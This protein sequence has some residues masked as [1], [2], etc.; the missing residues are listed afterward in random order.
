MVGGGKAEGLRLLD[1]AGERVPPFVVVPADLS[2]EQLPG[3]LAVFAED[4]RVAVR[5]SALD[6]DE[7]DQSLAGHH[8]SLLDVALSDVPEAVARVRASGGAD[9]A[10]PVVVQQM[11]SADVS[12]V[13]F[14]AEPA[15]VLD[16]AVVSAGAGA[17][18]VVAADRPS[19]T[20]TVSR[21]D[22]RRWTTAEAG[23]PD[24]P[25]GLVDDLVA[26]AARVESQRGRP[27][28][29]EWAWS[30][31]EGLWVLQAR[32]ITGL[33]DDDPVTLDN[34]N[35]VENYPGTCL[36][37]T[38]SFVPIS[39]RE[40]FTS[41]ARRLSGDEAVVEAFQPVLSRL[42]Q[43]Q[44]GRLFYR[45]ESWYAV[46][47]LVPFSKQYTRAW[48]ASLGVAQGGSSG[49]LVEVS[50]RTRLRVAWSLLQEL[51]T[52]PE[53]VRALAPKVQRVQDW[54]APRIES[55]TSLDELA[56][57]YQQI[58]TDL[59]AHWD[60]TLLND[61]RAF[62]LP[63]LLGA[64]L[65]PRRRRE[66]LWELFS[67][68][69]SIESLR[70]VAAM[71][72]L[73]EQAPQ[74]APELADVTTAEQAREWLAGP[75]PFAAEVREHVQRYG[76]RWLAEL[77]LESPTLRTD[78]LLV[79]QSLRTPLSLPARSHHEARLLRGPVRP[80]LARAGLE[81][82]ALRESSR[83]DRARVH[84]LVRRIALRAGELMVRDGLLDEPSQ[85]F[86]L[87]MDEVFAPRAG[88][89][90]V[91]T[92]RQDDHASFAQLPPIGRLTFAGEPFDLHPPVVGTVSGGDAAG[93]ERTGLLR[94]QGVSP[95]TAAGPVVVVE[96][97][98][99]A[100][101]LAG[102]VVVCAT[103]DPGW[104]F[105]LARCAALVA[106]QGSPLSH[107][108]IVA[109]E[110]GVPVVVGLAG[111]TNSF[112]SGERVEVDGRRGTVRRLDVD[113]GTR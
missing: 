56:E 105:L 98:S 72:H 111:A 50:R 112:T 78:P 108:A 36:P 47:S 44:S 79:V 107:T 31:S 93:G 68:V 81:A 2:L 100:G 33:P 99:R 54:A 106:E 35:I 13:V 49:P 70:P 87:T 34:A 88:L 83:L 92:S 32:P 82:I 38:L 66:R 19:C 10:I 84:G 18:S 46:M 73:A 5:S 58:L 28:D 110:L 48:R 97:A 91:I 69:A 15:G 96:D 86:W 45:L 30:S 21:V 37:L 20:V 59:V 89:R 63:A 22:G 29:V 103:T 6:E 23:A 53:Q 77:K 52:T 57:T 7:D 11:V 113:E 75:N 14:S 24:L 41:L 26:M 39:Y 64:T 61:V 85:V 94:G 55:A 4:T 109:R 90:S 17:G 67:G 43:A 76:D 60:V 25:P 104:V 71:A 1:D 65:A 12:G 74:R 16:L 95:G 102:A 8:L 51:R 101:D 42:V 40:V 62:V 80:R 9:H 27:V 3:L